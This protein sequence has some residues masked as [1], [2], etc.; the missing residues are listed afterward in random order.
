VTSQQVK[1]NVETEQ[2]PSSSPLTIKKNPEI[3]GPTNCP[4]LV[5]IVYRAQSIDMLELLSATLEKMLRP[6]V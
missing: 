2:H 3:T 6:P 1:V 5:A 4:R